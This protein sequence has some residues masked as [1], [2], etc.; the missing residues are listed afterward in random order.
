MKWIRESEKAHMVCHQGERNQRWRYS[1]EFRHIFQPFQ[2]FDVTKSLK[3]NLAQLRKFVIK[4][5]II[6]LLLQKWSSTPVPHN[7]T[8]Y[9]W[10]NE[11][12]YNYFTR[13]FHFLY[14]HLLYLSNSW[15]R[16]IAFSSQTK[17][18]TWIRCLSKQKW[19]GILAI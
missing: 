4:K 2:V 6:Y 8:Y 10:I 11:N 18:C 19:A 16:K 15:K 12:V 13:T 3:L 1:N 17:Y 5:Q 9:L 14:F 7:E